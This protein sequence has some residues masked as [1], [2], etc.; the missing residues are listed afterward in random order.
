MRIDEFIQ[1]LEGV[2]PDSNGYIARCPA[3]DDTT[4]AYLF[5]QVTMTV[6]YSNA[7]RAAVQEPY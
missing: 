5:Q 6:F 4:P 7:I 1:R 2:K 3:H